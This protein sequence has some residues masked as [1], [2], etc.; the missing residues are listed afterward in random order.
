[1]ISLSIPVI[2]EGK[3]DKARLSGIVDTRIITTDGFSV[4]NNKEKLSLIKILSQNGA[5]ILCD[6]DGGGKMIRSH[7]KSMLGVTVYDLYTPEIAGKEKR[8]RKASKDG[9]LGVEGIDSGILEKVF[10]AFVSAHPELS[11]DGKTTGKKEI[12][13]YDL[14]SLGLNG[15]DGASERRAEVCRKLGLPHDMTVNAFCEAVNIISYIQEIKRLL[16]D[17]RCI[18]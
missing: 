1:M 10:T 15:S 6:S 5:V 11:C 14:Y 4:F 2:V 17:T 13:K 9:Y 18:Q 3:Y 12:T 16:S 7:L 8:K